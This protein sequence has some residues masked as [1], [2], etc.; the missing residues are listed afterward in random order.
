VIA[1]CSGV[2]PGAFNELVVSAAGDAYVNGGAGTI[3]CVQPG[4]TMHEVAAELQWPNG[5]ALLDDDQTLV[6]ADSHAKHLLAFD[7]RN[8][9]SRMR[10]AAVGFSEQSPCRRVC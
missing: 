2:G 8:L 6:V 10:R 5:M 3:L 4:G 7:V 9:S 1:D